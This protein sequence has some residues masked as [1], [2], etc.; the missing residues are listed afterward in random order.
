MSDSTPIIFWLEYRGMRHRM[1][2]GETLV[3]RGS[4]VAFFL[5]EA[6]VSREHAVLRRTG[7]VV[8]LT[9]LGSS[10]GT[11]VNGEQITGSHKLEIGD[12]VRLGT[13]DLTFGVTRGVSP[14]SISPG[15]ELIEQRSVARPVMDLSTEPAFGSIE[16][17]ETLVA[18]PDNAESIE[19]LSTMVRSSVDRLVDSADRGRVKLGDLE[20][21]RVIA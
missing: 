19:E 4:R 2:D 6:S 11:F 10:N 13:A 14:S 20:R 12:H 17:L 21:A 7:D 3:G 18:N 9:D 5:D 8:M 16:V 1:H 15:I